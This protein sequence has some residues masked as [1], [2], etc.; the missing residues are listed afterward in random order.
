MNSLKDELTFFFSGQGMPYA[1][2]SI[3]VAVVVAVLFTAILSNNYVKDASIAV[4]DMDNSKFSH[5]LIEEINAS[6]YIKVSAVLNVPAEPQTLLYQ[7]RYLAVLYLPEGL[8]KNRY[9][10]SLNNIGIL[11]DNTSSAQTGSLKAELNTIIAI[12]NQKIGAEQVSGLG[13]SEG[14]TEAVMHNIALND[15]E[16]FNPTG[17][18]SNATAM[19]FVFFFSAMYFVFAT[20]GLVP[21]LRLEKKLAPELCERTPFDMM[22]RLVPYG[23]CLIAAL[24]VGLSVLKIV[25]DMSFSGNFF[26][27]L[28]SFVLLVI[29]LGLMSLLFGWNAANPGVAASRMV[30]FI[31]GGFILGGPTTPLAS[32]PDWV[33]V[34]SNVFPLVWQYRFTR[35]VIL[36]GASFMDCGREFGGFM[37]YT[38]VIALLFWLRFYKSRKDVLA[39]AAQAAEVPAAAP[40]IRAGGLT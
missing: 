19:G 3:M 16:L 15:R 28:L 13:L 23:I 33:Q 20:I 36:R 34:I 10:R 2:V 26:V 24:I 21:R 17:S 8:E 39:S 25:G 6:P 32:L 7:D 40:T 35:D 30:L 5:E 12:E 37:L 18:S 38:G 11:Y 1:K 4:I 27:L 29:S 14:E 22:L 9:S 31:P